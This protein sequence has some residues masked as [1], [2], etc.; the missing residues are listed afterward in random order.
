MKYIIY[1]GTEKEVIEADSVGLIT[2]DNR[3]FEL[4]YRH[5]DKEISLS[6]NKGSLVIL[7]KASNVVRIDSIR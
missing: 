4:Q 1:R 6:A 3:E 7:P 2:D 5:S